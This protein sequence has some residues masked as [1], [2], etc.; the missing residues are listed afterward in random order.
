MLR[1]ICGG[2]LKSKELKGCVGKGS[3]WKY[4]KSVACPV[5]SFYILNLHI[6]SRDKM[7]WDHVSDKRVWEQRE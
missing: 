5:L 6:Y 2:S 3:R 4:G 7:I 1:K